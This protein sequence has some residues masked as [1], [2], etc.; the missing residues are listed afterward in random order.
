MKNKILTICL[1]VIFIN[2]LKQASVSVYIERPPKSDSSDFLHF[3]VNNGDDKPIYEII[4]NIETVFNTGEIYDLKICEDK[5]LDDFIKINNYLNSKKNLQTE[6]DKNE[7]KKIKSKLEENCVKDTYNSYISVDET[8]RNLLFEQNI[9]ENYKLCVFGIMYYEVEKSYYYAAKNSLLTQ[10]GKIDQNFVFKDIK[11][12]IGFFNESKDSKF[13]DS[14]KNDTTKRCTLQYQTSE[15]NLNELRFTSSYY[16]NHVKNDISSIYIGYNFPNLINDP[17]IE[18]PILKKSKINVAKISENKSKLLKTQ[19]SSHTLSWQDRNTGIQKIQFSLVQ[20]EKDKKKELK[21]E[22]EILIR[23]SKKI[24]CDKEEEDITTN[25]SFKIPYEDFYKYNFIPVFCNEMFNK[26]N[27][28]NYNFIQENDCQIL[29]ENKIYIKKLGNNFIFDRYTESNLHSNTFS[30]EFDVFV[31][32][33]KFKMKNSFESIEFCGLEE[34]C[35]TILDKKLKIIFVVCFQKERIIGENKENQKE[36]QENFTGSYNF[37]LTQNEKA[38]EDN[39]HGYMK[40]RTQ[41]LNS[42]AMDNKKYKEINEKINKLDKKEVLQ[43]PGTRYSGVRYSGGHG[44]QSNNKP[45]YDIMATQIISVIGLVVFVVGFQVIGIVV[46]FISMIITGF[47][48]FF[49]KS[50][51]YEQTILASQAKNVKYI[52]ENCFGTFQKFEDFQ[53]Y[54]NFN[55]DDESLKDAIKTGKDEEIT[56]DNEYNQIEKSYKLVKLINPINDESLNFEPFFTE[57]INLHNVFADQIDFNSVLIQKN[58]FERFKNFIKIQPL[59]NPYKNS[60][61]NID[62]PHFILENSEN[63]LNIKNKSKNLLTNKL[64]NDLKDIK[65]KFK[66]KKKYNDLKDLIEKKRKF[67]F[68]LINIEERDTNKNSVELDNNILNE[69]PDLE[70]INK[71]EKR[72]SFDLGKSLDLNTIMQKKKKN[73][74]KLENEQSQDFDLGKSIVINSVKNNFIV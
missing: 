11:Q 42:A 38:N 25:L 37:I 57:I 14:Y 65:L 29:N 10:K 40:S 21:D 27:N 58:V 4:Y 34:N 31:L 44:N 72:H 15:V 8:S 68:G 33:W 47:L 61:I 3:Y 53:N 71:A 64:T 45:R 60:I 73:K 5:Y 32:N 20:I 49:K 36:I 18:V 12:V 74:E 19:I 55:F 9:S 13:R 24:N 16:I 1:I 22:E 30:L 23:V 54:I 59:K 6:Y 43:N 48:I 51:T 52:E 41:L 28:Q 17:D 67:D 66:K 63:S 35:D 2:I 70:N 26:N 39:S 7:Y 56:D 50:K 62:E 46:I 69:I